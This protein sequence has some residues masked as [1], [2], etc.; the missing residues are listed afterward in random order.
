MTKQDLKPKVKKPK[1]DA[2]RPCKSLSLSA[3]TQ[4][5]R[6]LCT[7]SIKTGKRKVSKELAEKFLGAGSGRRELVNLWIKCNGNVE[8]FICYSIFSAVTVFFRS[9]YCC[10]PSLQYIIYQHE[11]FAIAKE[12]FTARAEYTVK[13][14][15]GKKVDIQAGWYSETAMK[16]DL[17]LSPSLAFLNSDPGGLKYIKW[18]EASTT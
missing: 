1:K 18:F 9:Y 14:S 15:R 17:K 13:R 16:D 8:A 4:A 6:R 7:P 11:S 12:S 10:C 5:I 3:A 2:F